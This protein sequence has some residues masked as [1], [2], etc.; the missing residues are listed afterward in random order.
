MI[1][2][3]QKGEYR[4]PSYVFGRKVEVVPINID[5]AEL[6]ETIVVVEFLGECRAVDR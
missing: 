2:G 5:A 6:E 4:T 3:Y 1:A